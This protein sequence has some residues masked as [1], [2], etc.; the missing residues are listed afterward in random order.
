MQHLEPPKADFGFSEEE[1]DGTSTI[2]DAEIQ[3]S[4]ASGCSMRQCSRS[5]Y[6][7]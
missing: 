2:E 4:S 7:G 3:V 6:S 1:D 5:C